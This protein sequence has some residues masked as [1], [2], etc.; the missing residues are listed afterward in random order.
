MQ[1]SGK[2]LSSTSNK[3]LIEST[4]LWGF[5][6]KLLKLPIY[7]SIKLQEFPLLYMEAIGNWSVLHLL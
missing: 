3:N 2:A 4:G 6:K 7:K 1:L 5:F